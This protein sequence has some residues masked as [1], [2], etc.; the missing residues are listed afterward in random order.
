M[1][2]H[3]LMYYHG[4]LTNITMIAKVCVR[5]SRPD[6][7]FENRLVYIDNSLVRLSTL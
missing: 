2:Q 4:S 3:T 6:S 7:W 1:Y 5:E